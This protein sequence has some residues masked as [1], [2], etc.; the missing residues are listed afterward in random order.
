MSEIIVK[1]NHLTKKFKEYAAVNQ[2]SL[3]IP[4]GGI[5]GFIGRN[6]AGKTTF[7]KMISGL[8]YPTSGSIEL[9]GKKCNGSQNLFSRVGVLIEAPGIY[10]NMTAYENLKTKCMA[11]GIHNDTY[12]NETLE[13]VGLSDVR[14]KKAKHFSL[15]MKQRLGIAMALIGNPDLLVLDE[16]INGL[17]PQGIVEVR[18]TI[19]QLNKEKKIT[20]MISSHIL[21]ELSK[22]A[23]QY[24]IIDHGEVIETLTQEELSNRCRER[25][26]IKTVKP[27][28]TCT[29]LEEICNIHQYKV[30]DK[31]TI[32]I[33]EQL[34]QI[35][36]VN[37][38]LV[39]NEVPIDQIYLANDDLETYFLQMTGG[40]VNA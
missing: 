8:T 30:I 24:G 10:G 33:Y 19:I 12:L 39:L 14:K 18:D 26:E 5:Y 36:R 27:S 1:T 35:G 9:F 13:F 28:Q 15:G 3:E 7:M 40:V 22:I 23:T 31:N 21:E 25:I 17:D 6:G 34:E 11:Y 20:I 16:P 29:I 2:V 37:R 4:R 38:E 32:Y